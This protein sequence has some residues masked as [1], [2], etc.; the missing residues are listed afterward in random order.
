MH[1][2]DCGSDGA[3]LSSEASLWTTVDRVPDQAFF[4]FLS[5]NKVH[6]FSWS[7]AQRDRERDASRSSLGFQSLSI[8]ACSQG[9]EC[10][11]IFWNGVEVP[12]LQHTV[13]MF[14]GAPERVPGAP[15]GDGLW[16]R[17][18]ACVSGTSLLQMTRG[19]VDQQPSSLALR[20]GL[21]TAL[22]VS[23]VPGVR[24]PAA[25]PAH[26]PTLDW[27]PSANLG[28]MMPPSSPSPPECLE[29]PPL[30]SV[31]PAASQ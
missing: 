12:K 22:C 16:P 8:S 30:C 15:L 2:E 31:C 27:V 9:T 21:R 3:R 29:K 28:L 24:V 17:G 7:W 18:P 23:Q 25:A 1:S 14:H 6:I 4:P 10:P 26:S 5:C 13:V 11:D 20:G 19:V